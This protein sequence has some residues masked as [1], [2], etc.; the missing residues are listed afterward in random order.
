MFKKP[1]DS[2]IQVKKMF[3]INSYYF[4][5]PGAHHLVN[6]ISCSQCFTHMVPK[7]KFVGFL[8]TLKL[9]CF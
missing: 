4:I 9:L 6:N 8:T 5:I 3:I 7:N 1:V 2:I